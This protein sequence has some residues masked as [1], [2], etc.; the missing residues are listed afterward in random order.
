MQQWLQ[1]QFEDVFELV[2]DNKEKIN[3]TE[4]RDIFDACIQS[5][6]ALR[7]TGWRCEIL[8]REKRAVSVYAKERLILVPAGYEAAPSKVRA[9]IVHEIFGHAIRSANAEIDGD[10]I[11]RIG[12]AEYARIEESMMIV[13]EQC[14]AG[15]ADAMRGVNHY[16]AIG[17]A[18]G[19]TTEP[20][21]VTE[22]FHLF[23]NIHRLLVSA[24]DENKPSSAIPETARRLAQQQINRTFAGMTQTKP[25]VAH[26][27][28]IDYFTGINDA[29]IILNELV[30][31]DLLEEG[32][33]W[34]LSAKFNPV[35]ERRQ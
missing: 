9:L 15:N 34:L 10:D 25:G 22:L 14:L 17:A 21:T 26:M 7:E 33:K 20:R 27:K 2:D 8:R 3:D 1:E 28:D 13:L 24:N 4:I 31:A 11:G 29:V 16:L 19:V 32:M 23:E 30:E 18:V 35:T 12:T 5:T 6:P